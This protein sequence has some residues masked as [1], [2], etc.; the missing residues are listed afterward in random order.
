MRNRLG[1]VIMTGGQLNVAERPDGHAAGEYAGLTES[2]RV[3]SPDTTVRGPRSASM[4]QR[5]VWRYRRSRRRSRRFIPASETAEAGLP[6]GSMKS[7]QAPAV[8][9]SVPSSTVAA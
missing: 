5:R 3:S 4:L 6:K 8:A 2:R 7:V 1:T 9:G